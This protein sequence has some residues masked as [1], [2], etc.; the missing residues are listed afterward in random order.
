MGG[1]GA[2]AFVISEIVPISY[3]LVNNVTHLL[4]PTATECAHDL[5]RAYCHKILFR[6]T[7]L[8]RVVVAIAFEDV[9]FHL[10]IVPC[11]GLCVWCPTSAIFD[12]T[13]RQ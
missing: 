9:T 11:L 6:T 13:F 5:T 1:M 3:G 2:S 4:F 10:M 7:F 8:H 12:V